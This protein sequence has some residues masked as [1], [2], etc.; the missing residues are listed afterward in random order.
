[1]NQTAIDNSRFPADW[2]ERT[3]TC[4]RRCAGCDYCTAVLAEVLV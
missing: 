2:F 3:A 4:G 1:M